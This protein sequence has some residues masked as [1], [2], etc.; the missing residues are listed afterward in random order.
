MFTGLRTQPCE[1]TSADA[2]SIGRTPGYERNT[3][4]HDMPATAS[5][6][7]E[8]AKPSSTPVAPFLARFAWRNAAA[9]TP[10]GE[11]SYSAGYPPETSDEQ[12]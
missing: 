11:T 6:R 1:I 3:Q 9:P 4:G 5:Q 7:Q 12:T 10:R 8:E 2:M